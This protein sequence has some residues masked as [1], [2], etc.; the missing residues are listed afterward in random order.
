MTPTCPSPL[1]S[2][3]LRGTGRGR[4]WGFE[5]GAAHLKTPPFLPLFLPSEF[6]IRK[7]KGAGGMRRGQG[8]TRHNLSNKVL[9]KH[10]F[11]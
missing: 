3:P 1:P 2:S 10:W 8:M 7:G 5:V 6:R 4:N 9:E 11:F